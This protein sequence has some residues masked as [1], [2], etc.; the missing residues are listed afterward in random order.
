[1]NDTR[2]VILFFMILI[3]VSLIT[4]VI[5][6][7]NDSTDDPTSGSTGDSTDVHYLDPTAP[8]TFQNIN[9]Y[10]AASDTYSPT[11]TDNC[12]NASSM[13]WP[14]GMKYK[15]LRIYPRVCKSDI[16]KKVYSGYV[17]QNV[18]NKQVGFVPCGF[19]TSGMA[20]NDPLRFPKWNRVWNVQ[21][22]QHIV[23]KLVHLQ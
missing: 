11:I 8:Q 22:T 18:Y 20:V 2:K 17:I 9:Y 19:P 13:E 4:F 14:Y 15:Q 23:P 1:M 7:Q 12:G 3:I 21:H 5:L 6:K 16:D 10:T